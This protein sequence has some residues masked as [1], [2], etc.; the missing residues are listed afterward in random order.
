MLVT[1]DSGILLQQHKKDKNPCQGLGFGQRA[2]EDIP[3]AGDSENGGKEG[4]RAN[5]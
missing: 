4:M 5:S 2:I 3:G 1:L